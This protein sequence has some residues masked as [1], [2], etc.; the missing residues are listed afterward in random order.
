[1]TIGLKIAEGREAEV[2]AWASDAV[3]KLYRPGYG[4]HVTEASALATLEGGDV[5]PRLLGSVEIDGRHG[6]ILERLDGSDMLA[7]LERA[8][9][10]VLGLARTFADAHVRVNSVPAPA[11]LPDLKDVLAQRIDAGVQA[12]ALRDFV[13]RVLDRLPAGDRLCHGDLHPGNVLI[14]AGHARVID[15]ANATRG[16]AEADHA[17]TLWLLK[18]ADPL[19]STSR[20]FRRLMAIGRDLYARTYASHYRKRRPRAYAVAINVPVFDDAKWSRLLDALSSEVGHLAALLDDE[21]PAGTGGAVELL[22]GKSELRMVCSCPDQAEPCAHAAAVGYVTAAALD[23]DPFALMLLRGRGK[24][25]ILA[26]LRDR[27]QATPSAAAGMLARDAY[28]REL[29]PLPAAALPP[30]RPGHPPPL[31]MDPPAASG[32][33]REEL[34][35][36]AAMAA[37]RAWE[38]LRT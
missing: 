7:L 36:L 38:L 32:V 12:P 16:V 21:L 1:L 17:R 11:D 35:R 3:V 2:Y 31:A 13:F 18:R 34:A 28:R 15:W 26:L 29:A 4:G 19:P 9:W 23:A 27:R 6:L 24:E 14:V 37:R 8:P 33:G 5:A 25:D 10:R 20:L 22:P 30:H